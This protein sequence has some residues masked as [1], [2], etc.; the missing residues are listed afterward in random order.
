MKHISPHV[1]F[2]GMLHVLFPRTF[3]SKEKWCS[4]YFSQKSEFEILG[5]V[6]RVVNRRE[7]HIDC[8]GRAERYALIVPPLDTEQETDSVTQWKTIRR[9]FETVNAKRHGLFQKQYMIHKTSEESR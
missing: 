7:T 5:E 1:K 4:Q 3:V 9:G 8:V 2:K 6:L